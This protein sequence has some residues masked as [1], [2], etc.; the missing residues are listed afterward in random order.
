MA[1]S[2]AGKELR[3]ALVTIL[4]P[5]ITRK[6]ISTLD[7]QMFISII[8]MFLKMNVEHGIKKKCTFCGLCRHTFSKY[9]KRMVAKKRMKHERSSQK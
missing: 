5:E 7:I 8:I 4:T 3:E 6:G 2:I 9:W 1:V